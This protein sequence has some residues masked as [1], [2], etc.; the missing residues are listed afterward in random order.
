MQLNFLLYLIY[1]RN[2]IQQSTFEVTHHCI[3]RLLKTFAHTHDEINNYRSPKRT[4]SRHENNHS[5][6]VSNNIKTKNDKPVGSTPS[7]KELQEAEFE[8]IQKR[9]FQNR[10]ERTWN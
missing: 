1:S 8:Q 2:I 9:K 6:N 7:T 3:N 10:Q 4:R 5:Q